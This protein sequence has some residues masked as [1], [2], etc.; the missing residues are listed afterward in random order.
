MNDK[1]SFEDKMIKL[2]DIADKME[3]GKLTL[4]KSLE[5]FECGM[6]L[7]KDCEEYINTAKIKIEK[8]SGEET[9]EV[10]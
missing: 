5:S 1:I 2:D 9:T 6:K 8:I 7:I 4:E 3:S 10:D